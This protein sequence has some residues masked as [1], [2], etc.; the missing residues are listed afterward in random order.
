VAPSTSLMVRPI[1]AVTAATA[2]YMGQ[3]YAPPKDSIR[4]INP[5]AF[6]SP[7]QPVAPFGPPGTQPR[8]LQYLPGQNLNWVPRFDAEYSS[9]QLK[10]L[11]M[12]PVARIAIENVKDAL[13]KASWTFQL[14]PKPGETK[15]EL[16]TRMKGDETI[17]KLS[18]FFEKPDREHT[19][20]E[21]L[22]P[23]L[24]DMLVIDAVA[25][26]IRKTLGGEL[27]EL[28]RLPG[29][30]IVRYVDV[31]GL[32]PI[33]P[34]PAYAQNWWGM[35]LV[36]LTTDQLLYKPRNIV[37][38][39]TIAS[40]LYGTSP[41]EQLAKEIEIGIARLQFMLAYY[42][43]GSIPG[44][45]Q[46]VPKGIT[47]E[48]LREAML[49][50][51][52]ELA[53]NFAKR[54]QVRLIQGFADAAKGEKDQI[55]MTKEQLLLDQASFENHVREIFFGIGSS[56]QRMMKAMNRA[57]AEQSDDAAETEGTLPYFGWL[58]SSVMDY[59]V[60]YKIGLPEYEWVPDPFKEPSFEKMAKALN[61]IMAKPV[62]TINEAREKI[63]EE[64]RSEPEADMLGTTT[65]TGW[66]PIGMAVAVAGGEMDEKGNVTITKPE[67]APGDEAAGGK[68]NGKPASA[69]GK[70]N[71]KPAEA[72]KRA[73]VNRSREYF[74]FAAGASYLEKYSESQERDDHGRW[75][76]GGGGGSSPAEDAGPQT[77]SGEK[78]SGHTTSPLT[79]QNGDKVRLADTYYHGGP[80][81]HQT[82]AANPVV[83]LTPE[84][85]S[86][87]FHGENL[88]SVSATTLVG[89]R[90]DLKIYTMPGNDIDDLH[91]K[92]R[93]VAGLR[94]KGYVAAISADGRTMAWFSSI[95][96]DSVHVHKSFTP[97]REVSKASAHDTR[98]AVI[99]PGRSLPQTIVATHHTEKVLRDQFKQM[100]R[101]T[102][103]IL[104]KALGLGKS[105]KSDAFQDIDAAIRENWKTIADDTWQEFEAAALA[106]AA[107]G[108]VQ[109]QLDNSKLISKINKQ[110]SEWARE[111][112]AELVGMR[113]TETGRL[114]K[115]PDAEWAITDATR[116]KLRRAVAD[117]FETEDATLATIEQAI[118][119][120][121]IF[122]DQ[123]AT[124]I[125]RT[126]M[127]RAQT[128][129]NLMSWRESGEVVEVG[130]HLSAD[131]EDASNCDCSDNADN[132]PYPVDEV[133]EFP[134]HPNCLCALV[135]ETL[136]GEEE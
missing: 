25:L 44:M 29:E 102:T 39:T 69:V 16:A 17:L 128:L 38:R 88:H 68:P 91:S 107:Q 115:N 2:R 57:S 43:E 103:K 48:K 40:Q 113:R 45:L 49:S 96:T 98:R 82:L 121:G 74:G 108:A 99:H 19:W 135:L 36:N 94:N 67:P 11:A 86:A 125:A 61:E 12:Y 65:A 132:S 24:D 97:V 46:I 14:K 31:N 118:I 54:W 90:T 72:D 52:S 3:L 13:C 70:P 4:G 81:E 55:I 34:D 56:P 10:E 62:I 117:V 58:K 130:W 131:H 71:G 101:K 84:S 100:R 116:D 32:T 77:W 60:N 50:V 104:Q 92:P 76:E 1:A 109:L 120:A 75:T 93:T 5:D 20:E 33:A 7:L 28:I 78:Y 37:P 134:A 126:E 59:I 26:Q 8:G 83:F 89:S 6:Y 53:G 105:D 47:T 129:S 30:S 95:K 9:A 18:R 87:L 64:K 42:T 79:D 111:R 124:M 119:K 63:G 23:I 35:P 73:P 22:R 110:A 106:G 27:V 123:R 41:V 80:A 114:V 51:N 15:K 136:R 133:P 21:W 66:V 112:S 85:H 127:S 122:D